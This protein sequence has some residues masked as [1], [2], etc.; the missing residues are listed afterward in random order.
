M[1]TL[2]IDGNNLLHRVFWV[3]NLNNNPDKML[4]VSMFLASIKTYVEMFAPEKVFMCWDEK[5][6]GQENVRHQLNPNYK[7]TRNKEENQEVYSCTTIIKELVGYLGIK[8]LFPYKYE[9][10]D[11]MGYLCQNIPGKKVIVTVDKDLYQLI[12]SDVSVYTPI[13]KCLVTTENFE[14]VA[15]CKI[16]EF[17]TIKALKG[18]KSDNIEGLSGFGDKKIQRY[19]NGE[20]QLTTEQQK[21]LDHNL[22]IMDLNKG[23]LTDAIEVKYIKDQLEINQPSDFNK[24]INTCTE[25]KFEKILKN[26]ERWYELFFFKNAY[27]D[28]LTTLFN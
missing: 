20:I 3:C 6:D 16:Y 8:N 5:P 21:L 25:L 18:D 14:T 24:F 19:F 4:H 28:L 11:I 13:K 10:D 27:T 2:I 7:A 12:N 1:K 17:V 23:G 15:N 22:L 26:K 9:A